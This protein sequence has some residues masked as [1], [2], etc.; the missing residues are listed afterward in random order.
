MKKIKEIIFVNESG[1]EEGIEEAEKYIKKA[2]K[3]AV[4]FFKFPSG[5]QVSVTLVDE[6]HIRELNREYRNV[7]S[8]TDVLSFPWRRPIP[9]VPG[10]SGTSCCAGTWP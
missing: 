6:D 9:G 3:T 2:V 7:D 1:S 10:S 8:S 4:G 5:Y